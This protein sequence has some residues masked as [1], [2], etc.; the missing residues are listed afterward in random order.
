M[1][2]EPW[3]NLAEEDMLL[4]TVENGTRLVDDESHLTIE[5]MALN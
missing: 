2:Q 5:L 1:I 3:A 4:E